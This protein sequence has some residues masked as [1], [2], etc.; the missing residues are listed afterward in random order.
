MI[1]QSK[2]SNTTES[3]TAAFPYPER[4]GYLFQEAILKKSHTG[5]FDINENHYPEN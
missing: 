1:L 4:V 5:F 3:H 2:S